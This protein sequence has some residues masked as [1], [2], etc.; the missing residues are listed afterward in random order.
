LALTDERR[1]YARYDAS[2]AGRH[3]HVVDAVVNL[4]PF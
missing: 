2:G 3:G 4:T 1:G